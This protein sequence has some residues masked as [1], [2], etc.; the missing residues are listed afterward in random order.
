MGYVVYSLKEFLE[1]FRRLGERVLISKIELPLY[2]VFLE[3]V[4]YFLSKL[5]V[6][7]LNMKGSLKERK[8][9]SLARR[10]AREFYIYISPWLI[11]LVVFNLGPILASLALSFTSW[12]ILT[13]ARFIGIEN[14]KTCFFGDDLFWKSIS[15]TFYYLL[16]VPVR[17]FIGLIIALLLNQKIKAMA[18]FRTI[19][20]LPSVISGVAVSLLWL[21]IFNPEFGILNYLLWRFFRIQGPAWLFDERW[22]IPSFIIMSL[23]GVGGNMI[24]YLAALQGV[25]TILYEAA[26]LDGATPWAK[27]WHITIPM[28]SPAILFNLVM[29]MIASFQI[30]TPGFIMTNGGPNNASLFYVLYLYRNAFQYFKMGYASA[31]AWILFILILSFTL[32]TFKSS[33]LWVFYSGEIKG[34]R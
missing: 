25:P 9:G 30:F 14:Y 22:V 5:L 1:T 3:F 13:P 2:L 12:D 10:E 24:I 6:G 26:E 20:Y 33:P 29:S 7:G 4:N 18:F 19:Y 28:I 8:I 11:G 21:W 16:S 17:L 31:L 23:W 15:V 27:F 32:I 34:G